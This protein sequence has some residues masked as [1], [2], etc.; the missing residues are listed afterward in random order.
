MTNK[1]LWNEYNAAKDKTCRVTNVSLPSQPDAPPAPAIFFLSIFGLLTLYSTYMLRASLAVADPKI[2]KMVPEA[3]VDFQF[4][5]LGDHFVAGSI[6]ADFC[7]QMYMW[8]MHM[9][10][11]SMWHMLHVHVVHGHLS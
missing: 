9:W 5:P 3:F 8:H 7:G 4:R 2:Q 10:Q 6:F 1:Q 11:L